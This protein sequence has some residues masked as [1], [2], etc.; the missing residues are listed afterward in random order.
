RAYIDETSKLA[1]L[2]TYRH[3]LNNYINEIE[4]KIDDV[5]DANLKKEI[6]ILLELAFE[7]IK[8]SKELVV[9]QGLSTIGERLKMLQAS[10]Y[11]KKTFTIFSL[12]C[13]L[14]ERY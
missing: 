4:L 13:M 12:K 14:L 11:K 10:K 2:T 7:Q 9:I 5:K 3:G 8:L 6:K 1:Y